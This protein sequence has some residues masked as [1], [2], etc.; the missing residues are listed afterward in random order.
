LG[1]LVGIGAP[2]G[3]LASSVASS[4]YHTLVLGSRDEDMALAYNR[5][6]GLGGGLVAV[7][8]GRIVA[9]LPLPVGGFISDAPLPAVAEGIARINGWARDLGSPVDDLFLVQRYFTY[10]GVPFFR[11]TPWGIYDVK[12]HVFLPSAID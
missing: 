1:F 9:E 4:P 7:Q 5:M 8:Q 2:L 3:G 11:L 10:T 6:V 12:E